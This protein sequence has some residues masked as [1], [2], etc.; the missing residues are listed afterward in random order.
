MILFFECIS[1]N[2]IAVSTSEKLPETEIEKLCWLFGGAEFKNKESI[3]ETYIGPRKEMVTPW[4]TNALEI[5]QNMGIK[6]I[7]RIEEYHV[8]K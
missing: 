1:K 4:S 2:I 7:I 8:K 3:A 5:T 6:G